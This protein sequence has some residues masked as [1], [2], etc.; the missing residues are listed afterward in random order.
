LDNI[1]LSGSSL[2]PLLNVHAGSKMVVLSWSA[3]S[4][5]LQAA[6]TPVGV[7]TNVPGAVSPFTNST[8]GLEKFFRL[9]K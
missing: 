5:G 7:F 2:P 6:P 1:T 3:S 9:S 8:A 4:F